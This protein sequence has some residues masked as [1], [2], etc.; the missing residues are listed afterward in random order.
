MSL[1]LKKFAKKVSKFLPNS[2]NHKI[3][4][5]RKKWFESF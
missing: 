4:R 3:E 2:E 5:N 1:N